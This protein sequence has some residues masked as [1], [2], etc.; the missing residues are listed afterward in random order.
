MCFKTLTQTEPRALLQLSA[1]GL[2]PL[3]SASF[4]RPGARFVTVLRASTRLMLANDRPPASFLFQV[5]LAQLGRHLGKTFNLPPTSWWSSTC[6]KISSNALAAGISKHDVPSLC[7]ANSPVT[8]VPM[9]P[10]PR[11]ADVVWGPTH[12]CLCLGQIPVPTAH[13]PA[14][15]TRQP[16][17]AVPPEDATHPSGLPAPCKTHATH[18]IVS[19]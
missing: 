18:Y 11:L 10:S 17:V 14:P 9:V 6:T 3:Q 16:L 5:S 2:K 4:C 13:P 15:D 7:N 19:S 12:V 8:C 1:P